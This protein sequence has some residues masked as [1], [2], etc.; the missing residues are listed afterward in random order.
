[1]KILCTPKLRFRVRRFF[2]HARWHLTAH[3]PLA[4]SGRFRA[5]KAGR[6]GGLLTER[7]GKFFSLHSF[8]AHCQL[9][10]FLSP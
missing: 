2:T 5:S 6:S 8:F 7:R 1:M 10:T 3:I 4:I 9:F